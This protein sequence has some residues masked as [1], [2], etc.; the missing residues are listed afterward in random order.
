MPT[1]R[2]ASLLL[3]TRLKSLE[4]MGPR[5]CARLELTLPVP[6]ELSFPHQPTLSL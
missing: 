1:R 5:T 4:V 6:S 3:T 2:R